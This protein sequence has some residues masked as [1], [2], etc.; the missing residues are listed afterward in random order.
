[1]SLIQDLSAALELKKDSEIKAILAELEKAVVAQAASASQ[2]IPDVLVKVLV[3][4]A[5]WA[6]RSHSNEVMVIRVLP[7]LCS[8]LLRAVNLAEPTAD[9]LLRDY[10]SK[11]KTLANNIM[12][13]NIPSIKH[14]LEM[15]NQLVSPENFENI[16]SSEDDREKV[17]HYFTSEPQRHVKR[18]K[19][20]WIQQQQEQQMQELQKKQEELK[21]QQEVERQKQA[22][23]IRMQ[24]QQRQQA[25][26]APQEQKYPQKSVSAAASA[27]A[28][29]LKSAGVAA[30]NPGASAA[31]APVQPQPLKPQ[32]Q[33]LAQP[34]SIE[35]KSPPPQVFTQ[36]EIA[37]NEKRLGR[38]KDLANKS[39][40]DTEAEQDKEHE[41]QLKPMQL[42][43]KWTDQ[44]LKDEAKKQQ[45]K[46]SSPAKVSSPKEKDLKNLDLLLR[47]E[48]VK[49]EEEKA[50]LKAKE[51]EKKNKKNPQTS[52][53]QPVKS[54]KVQDQEVVKNTL[55]GLINAVQ[56]DFSALKSTLK[57]NAFKF[58]A[59]NY[60]R[61]LKP[62]I[63]NALKQKISFPQY[64][65]R[66]GAVILLCDAGL[67]PP[68][69]FLK[70]QDISSA[71]K[72]L[73][74]HLLKQQPVLPENKTK[75]ATSVI[76]DKKISGFLNF[77]DRYGDVNGCFEDADDRDYSAPKIIAQTKEGLTAVPP[78]PYTTL[79]HTVVR[80]AITKDKNSTL[81]PIRDFLFVRLLI[82]EGQADI[83]APDSFGRTP[84]FWL[85][86]S[87]I[88]Y[89]KESDEKLLDYFLSHPDIR[90]DFTTT[91]ISHLSFADRDTLPAERSVL[92]YFGRIS[93]SCLHRRFEQQ[94]RVKNLE[95][96]DH[97]KDLRSLSYE[98]IINAPLVNIDRSEEEEAEFVRARKIDHEN[99]KAKTE[100][101]IKRSVK[102]LKLLLEK[103]HQQYATRVIP[104]KLDAKKIWD[105][106]F[107]KF[108][109]QEHAQVEEENWTTT[110]HDAQMRINIRNGTA[111][112]PGSKFYKIQ[113]E[114][115]AEI[116]KINGKEEKAN[117]QAKSE[118]E[119]K[120]E[121]VITA[122]N[123]TREGGD[124][125]KAF[126]SP[127]SN[128]DHLALYKACLAVISQIGVAPQPVAAA[129]QVAGQSQQARS[130][131]VPSSQ[132]AETKSQQ[133]AAPA[134]A[135]TPI[136]AAQ[137]A[138]V[139]APKAV[140]QSQQSAPVPTLR[141][142]EAK[143]QQVPAPAAT[144][145]PTT[146]AS[147]AP[148]P[149]GFS[150]IGQEIDFSNSF[151][152]A[153]NP[154]GAMSS[155]LDEQPL[156]EFGKKE[157]RP[158]F[159]LEVSVPEGGA[160]ASSDKSAE[161]NKLKHT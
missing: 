60:K 27:S 133:A 84:L 93:I 20:V 114:I 19:E 126:S 160:A 110:Q 7:N 103:I 22:E 65:E 21:K 26:A 58:T 97:R 55:E 100:N 6:T 89:G 158:R 90:F 4:L 42:G 15:S 8:R 142:M 112:K 102:I 127:T 115:R 113:E 144:P 94:S 135:T 123:K 77:I 122:I 57:Q 130:A 95:N 134:P 148:T 54:N 52:A 96:P 11:L 99:W 88:V 50:K 111:F 74:W 136:P 36:K 119:K 83:N 149:F 56:F 146:Q 13:G 109:H 62:A 139:V 29:A 82:E 91:A 61:F 120:I 76:Y 116:A 49:K 48:E 2:E 28:P 128:A 73:L 70:A 72:H 12:T 151:S 107:E 154:F 18:Q 16:F 125:G 33:Q 46:P 40:L 31:N 44:A 17:R 71:R 35:Q 14:L 131:P 78:S 92:D 38:I 75:K 59:E 159:G 3:Q 79:L 87:F 129:P 86:E 121:G 9:Y 138:A 156:F 64:V 51:A 37:Q 106:L 152:A 105:K 137:A 23:Q 101:S 98:D 43:R 39:W 108:L 41:R 81:D 68:E 5:V 117:E 1:M 140:V 32:Q 150:G 153:A 155:Q 34:P 118:I 85:I 132:P 141:P 66:L 80:R 25:A 63:L 147:E 104:E 10:L 67:K 45:K 124:E 161:L 24:E 143:S 157:V 53:A 145:I 69:E 30:A 47:E